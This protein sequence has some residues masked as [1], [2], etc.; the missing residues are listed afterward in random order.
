MATR[1]GAL[2]AFRRTSI[3]FC[4]PLIDLGLDRAAT[5]ADYPRHGFA[6]APAEQL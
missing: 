3:E 4:F 1:K 2:A 6:S 5:Q